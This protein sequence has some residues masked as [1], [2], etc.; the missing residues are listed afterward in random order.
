[1]ICML[2]KDKSIQNFIN[3]K[4]NF[5]KFIPCFVL[6][7]IVVLCF[8]FCCY[9]IIFFYHL[10]SHNLQTDFCEYN[11]EWLFNC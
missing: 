4:E 11:V 8:S 9:R 2:Y 10:T 5:I 7:C 1:M 3:K 6:F